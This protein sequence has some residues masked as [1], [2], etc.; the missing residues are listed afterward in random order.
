MGIIKTYVI[1]PTVGIFK[2]IESTPRELFT[3]T[4]TGILWAGF[5]AIIQSL[6]LRKEWCWNGRWGLVGFG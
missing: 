6:G 5:V 3:L 4:S 1:Q 2:I